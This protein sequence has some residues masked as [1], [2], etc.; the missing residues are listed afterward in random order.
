MYS[1]ILRALHIGGLAVL[2]T[3]S[4][5]PTRSVQAATAAEIDKEVDLALEKLYAGS[6]TA[7]EFADL[8][9]GILVFPNVVKG[10]LIIGGEY[11]QGA[12]RIDGETVG[13]YNTL[14]GSFGLQAGAQSFGYAMFFMSEEALDYLDRSDGWEVGVGPTVVAVDK[15]MAG[16]LSSSTA[17]DDIYAF[18]FDQEGLMAGF[19]LEGSK[20]SRIQPEE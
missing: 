10:G 14:G 9:K 16:N 15:G 20:I 1:R 12:L 2:L 7:R 11:G 17:Q 6:P 8:A 3:L 4:L 13:Y 5:G 18:F 19:N